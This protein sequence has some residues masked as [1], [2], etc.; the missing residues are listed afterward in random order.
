MKAT[1]IHREGDIWQECCKKE[2]QIGKSAHNLIEKFSNTTKRSPVKVIFSLFFTNCF[3][4]LIPE[5]IMVCRRTDALCVCI[6]TPEVP[7][8]SVI[9]V[10][11]TM[12]M[13]SHLYWTWFAQKCEKVFSQQFYWCNWIC[14]EHLNVQCYALIWTH[15]PEI[16]QQGCQCMSA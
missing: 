16:S 2:R 1:Q 5:H 15:A 11:V 10:Q 4:V 13:P 9:L 6:V 7:F 8:I 12:K 3:C 14:I